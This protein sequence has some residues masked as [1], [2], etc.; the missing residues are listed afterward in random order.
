MKNILGKTPEAI[1]LGILGTMATGVVPMNSTM[2]IILG[3]YASISTVV[4]MILKYKQQSATNPKIKL[5]L[6]KENK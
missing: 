1:A 4:S 3:I 2:A 6:T 5:P